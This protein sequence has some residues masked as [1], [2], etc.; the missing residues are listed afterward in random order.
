MVS[1]HKRKDQNVKLLLFF[2]PFFLMTVFGFPLFENGRKNKPSTEIKTIEEVIVE[3]KNGNQRFLDNKSINTDYAQQILKTKNE[4]HPHTLVL[5][6]VDSRVPPEIIFDQGIGNL[7]VT[8]VAGNVEDDNILGSMEFATKIKHAKLILVLGHSHCGAVKGA[9]ENVKLEHLTQLVSQIK[10]AIV[11]GE[12]NPLS[13]QSMDV[14]SKENIKRTIQDILDKS[15]TLRL[16]VKNKEIKIIGA[17]YEVA[18]GKVV[19]L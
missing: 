7:F 13:N 18:T 15:S 5:S 19:F 9:I 14:S 12:I 1:N 3:L 2:F 11:V 16:Q 10:P 6:C 4:Q 17:F 8:R